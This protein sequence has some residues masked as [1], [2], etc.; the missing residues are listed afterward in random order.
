MLTKRGTEGTP[1]NH[2][3]KVVKLRSY[4]A[5]FHQGGQ[6][7]GVPVGHFYLGGQIEGVQWVI[8]TRGSN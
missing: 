6:N 3:T 5:P 8:F 1:M 7:E 2:F 4:N